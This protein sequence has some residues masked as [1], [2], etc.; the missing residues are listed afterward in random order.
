MSLLLPDCRQ[1][2]KVTSS[3]TPTKCTLHIGYL[4]IPYFAYMF[5][6][7]SHHFQGELNVF[8]T[9]NHLLLQSYSLWYIG[10]VVKCKIYDFVGLQWKVLKCGAGER[11]KRSVGLIMWEMKKYYLESRSRGIFYMRYVSRRAACGRSP[12]EIVGSNPTGGM[13]IC[14][15]WVS[16]V[17]R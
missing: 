1:D 9:Q 8:I 10:C 4:S 12:A 2:R 6:C 13:N 15:L 14:L 16:C 7:I 5:R 11:W 17:V 3:H